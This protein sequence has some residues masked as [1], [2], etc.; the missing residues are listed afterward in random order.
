MPNSLIPTSNRIPE[1]LDHRSHRHLF[2][3]RHHQRRK[4]GPQNH[5]PKHQMPFNIH[6]PNWDHRD[7]GKRLRLP[8]NLLIENA[9]D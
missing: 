5:S 7:R 3:P 4:S 2:T 8:S 6:I 9:S 1:P